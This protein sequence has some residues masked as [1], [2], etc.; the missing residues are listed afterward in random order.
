MIIVNE[1]APGD[2]EMIVVGASVFPT[3]CSVQPSYVSECVTRAVFYGACDAISGG[4]QGRRWRNVL[5]VLAERASRYPPSASSLG[6]AV[7]RPRPTRMDLDR[8]ACF[9]FTSVFRPSFWSLSSIR[10]A[11]FWV[12]DATR[13]M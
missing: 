8:S 10:L 11:P 3:R 2:L 4:D 5:N 9:R 1:A 6:S 13:G 7:P 12:G